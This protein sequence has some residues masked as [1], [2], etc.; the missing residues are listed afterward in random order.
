VAAGVSAG[1]FSLDQSLGRDCIFDLSRLCRAGTPSH[2][3]VRVIGRDKRKDT[4][5]GGELEWCRQVATL[6]PMQG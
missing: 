6:F 3:G 1:N 2:D 4:Y 5:S